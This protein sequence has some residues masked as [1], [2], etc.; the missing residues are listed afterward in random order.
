[1]SSQ[2]PHLLGIKGIDTQMPTYHIIFN[3]IKNFP[4]SRLDA[5]FGISAIALI[6][7]IHTA[8][9][10]WGSKFRFF[11]ILATGQFGFVVVLYTLIVYCMD[12]GRNHSVVKIMKKLPMGFHS[13]DMSAL[14]GGTE[15]LE[16]CWGPAI[17]I[18]IIGVLEHM[19]AAKAL[20]IYMFLLLSLLWL[21]LIK[22]N[23]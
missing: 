18:V 9:K 23:L 20:G 2:L 4:A 15:L 8:H 13:L 7:L 14:Q 17:T 22:V 5:W 6:L 3:T 19:A 16:A 11:N 21:L 1:M 10:K 12:I